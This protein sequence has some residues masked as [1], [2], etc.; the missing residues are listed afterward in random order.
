VAIEIALWGLT[1]AFI[2]QIWGNSMIQI[3]TSDNIYRFWLKAYPPYVWR[4]C[5]PALWWAWS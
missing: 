2:H 5:P 1:K 3:L 4:P